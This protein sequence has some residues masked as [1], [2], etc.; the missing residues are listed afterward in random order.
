M[1]MNS[2]VLHVVFPR[3]VLALLEVAAAVAI[4]R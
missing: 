2:A 3:A 4:G 1:Y